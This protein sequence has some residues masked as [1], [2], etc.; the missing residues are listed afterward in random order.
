M[1]ER[2]RAR[3]L[4]RMHIPMK[5]DDQFHLRGR[6]RPGTRPA[7]RPPKAMQAEWAAKLRASGFEDLESRSGTLSNRGMVTVGDDEDTVRMT[8]ERRAETETYY[9]DAR[10]AARSRRFASRFDR[11]VWALHA[12]RVSDADIALRLG[13]NYTKARK[14]VKRTLA[15]MREEAGRDVNPVNPVNPVKASGRDK[16]DRLAR[17]LDLDLLVTLVGRLA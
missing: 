9:D 14:S 1:K 10:E 5:W 12:E 4:A 16:V 6:E 17:A 15:A 8:P 7:Q 2:D 13:T 3:T 11:D